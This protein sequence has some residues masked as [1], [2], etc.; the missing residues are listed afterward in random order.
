MARMLSVTQWE[1]SPR[2]AL[3]FSPHLP[4]FSYLHRCPPQKSE[5]CR[6]P[7]EMRLSF[8]ETREYEGVMETYPCF[9]LAVD[10]SSFFLVTTG[11]SSPCALDT[12]GEPFPC[13]CIAISSRNPCVTGVCRRQF[14]A[15]PANKAL[16]RAHPNTALQATP[17][18]TPSPDKGG[19]A[20][21][22][23]AYCLYCVSL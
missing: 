20:C 15:P 7:D 2:S 12:A 10:P 21:R 16:F 13:V 6:E 23:A 9:C 11:D 17:R 22:A 4:A 18:A 8:S 5:H 1:N 19:V 14:S 3:S